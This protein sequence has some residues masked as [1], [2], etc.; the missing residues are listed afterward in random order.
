MQVLGN[1]FRVVHFLLFSFV[2]AV[3]FCP[4]MFGRTSDIRLSILVGHGGTWALSR[5]ALSTWALGT[6]ALGTW[7]HGQLLGQERAL[8]F[9][10]GFPA[11]A[12][13]MWQARTNKYEHRLKLTNP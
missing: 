8:S 2:N 10:R 7:V 12:H 9:T 1:H 11:V 5:W 4:A 6:W 3:V 13:Q